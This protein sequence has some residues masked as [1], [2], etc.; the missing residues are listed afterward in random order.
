MTFIPRHIYTKL[1][2]HLSE[3]EISLILGPRQSGKTTIMKKLQKELQQQNKST[4]FLNLDINEDKQFFQT[5]HTLIDYIKSKISNK[6]AVIFIDEIH[7]L[8][9]AGLFLK[10]L[11]D[12]K[13]K[14]KFIISGSGSLELKANIIEPMTG[15]KKIFYC[16]PISFTEFITYK[17]NTTEK[18]A[19]TLLDQNPLQTSRLV[20]EYINYGGYPRVI[21]TQTHQN[22]INILTEIFKSY[23]EKDILLLLNIQRD[24]AFRNLIKLLATQTGN[25]I[26]YNELSSTLGLNLKTLKKYLYL[27]EKTFI[28]SLTPPFFQNARKELTKSPK[29]YFLDLGLLH[30][31][32]GILPSLQNQI[33]GNTFENAC[34]LRLKEL[35]LFHQIHF[36]RT[37]SGAEIDFI[38]HSS[39]TGQPIPIEIKLNPK[40]NILGKSLINFIKKYQSKQSFIYSLNTKHIS[41]KFNTHTIPFHHLPKI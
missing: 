32:Q 34:F 27:L 13:T 23:I 37:K 1:K 20:N 31:A 30:L 21:S 9:N 3:P 15:R 24:Q 35:N 8:T 7:R 38:I 4:L 6:P 26:N 22:K 25:L 40:K 10:G 5:Q 29:V 12:L 36:W 11:Y 16:L 33:T 41:S 2:N 14:Y 28:I 18:K 17:L 19:K 39:K